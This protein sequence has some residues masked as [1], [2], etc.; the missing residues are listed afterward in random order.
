MK[1]QKD[2]YIVERITRKRIPVIV[3]LAVT[4]VLLGA[5]SR[6]AESK[7]DYSNQK[8]TGR[9]ISI[10]GTRIT[11]QNNGARAQEESGAWQDIGGNSDSTIPDG[12]SGNDLG[13]VEREGQIPPE[14]PEGNGPDDG[15][16]PPK[17]PDRNRQDNGQRPSNGPE[18]NGPRDGRKAPGKMTEDEAVTLDLEGARVQVEN[19]T[20]TTEGT[21]EDISVDAILVVEFGENNEVKTVT[22]K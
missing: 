15:Q 1:T 19:G 2:F 17:K 21:L 8:L 3:A 20:E 7:V 22:V 4:A 9:V 18:G 5:C 14:K 12:V 6:D 16:E 10:D 13:P 11:L